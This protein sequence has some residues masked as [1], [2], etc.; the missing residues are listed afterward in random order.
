M[1]NH[2]VGQGWPVEA[3][4]SVEYAPLSQWPRSAYKQPSPFVWRNAILIVSLLL[5]LTWS[6][7]SLASW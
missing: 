7:E 3:S 2:D 4:G 5:V 1:K 6:L